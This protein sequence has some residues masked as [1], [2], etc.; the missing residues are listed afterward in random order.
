LHRRLSKT[1][2]VVEIIVSNS[3]RWISGA[4]LCGVSGMARQ[5]DAADRRRLS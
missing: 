2:F 5:I 3:G 4:L 1:D